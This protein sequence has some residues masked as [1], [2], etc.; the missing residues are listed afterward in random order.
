MIPARAR[1]QDS[2]RDFTPLLHSSLADSVRLP[3][4]A[5]SQKI[6][7]NQCR[8]ED[9][10]SIWLAAARIWTRVPLANFHSRTVYRPSTGHQSLR[11][12]ACHVTRRYTAAAHCQCT[13]VS[14][15]VGCGPQQS[16]QAGRHTS[17]A[18]E[19]STNGSRIWL[20]QQGFGRTIGK[21]SQPAA[22]TTLP[23]VDGAACSSARPTLVKGNV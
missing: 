13:R 22:P 7:S 2:K 17:S 14:L 23:V 8:L 20:Q 1:A 16:V 21:L 12:S 9:R 3:T 6:H 15:A 4:H 19:S 5:E 18:S 10:S 11:R